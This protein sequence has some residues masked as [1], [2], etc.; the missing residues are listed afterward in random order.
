MFRVFGLR[1]TPVA[2]LMLAIMASGPSLLQAR[3]AD[4]RETEGIA[5]LNRCNARMALPELDPIREKVLLTSPALSTPVSILSNHNL[6]TPL[7]QA[8]IAKWS[9][10]RDLCEAEFREFVQSPRALPRATPFERQ[11]IGLIFDEGLTFIRG[12]VL[13]LY[14]RRLDYGDFAARRA[15][16]SIEIQRAQQHIPRS[17]FDK[18]STTPLVPV[19]RDF[20]APPRFALLA[21]CSYGILSIARASTAEGALGRTRRSNHLRRLIRPAAGSTPVPRP[22][23]A[24]WRR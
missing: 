3:P 4:H 12:L 20:P 7:E 24:P 8:A 21:E 10:I 19:E 16:A 23:R 18:G 15:A 11:Q 2:F 5:I 6:P 14:E 1:T 17:A 13:A 9:E 22:E